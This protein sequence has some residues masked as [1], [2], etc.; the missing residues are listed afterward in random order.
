MSFLGY[1]M[2][3]FNVTSL[4]MWVSTISHQYCMTGS[5]MISFYNHLFHYLF[6]WESLTLPSKSQLLPLISQTQPSS[7]PFPQQEAWGCQLL[8]RRHHHRSGDSSDDND[9]KNEFLNLQQ[10]PFPECGCDLLLLPSFW[11]SSIYSHPDQLPGWD[12]DE[13]PV[14]ELFILDDTFSKASGVNYGPRFNAS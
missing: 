3:G 14:G 5:N 10:N 2:T 9:K 8:C 4:L 6:I 11:L 7:C 13:H 12:G 1:C